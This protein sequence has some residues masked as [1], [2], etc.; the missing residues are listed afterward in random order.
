MV[1]RRRDQLAATLPYTT[2]MPAVVVD[3][4]I[5]NISKI[6]LRTRPVEVACFLTML[7]SSTLYFRRQ[8][9][10]DENIECAASG[11]P[12]PEKSDTEPDRQSLHR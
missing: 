2:V 9:A 1:G 11:N 5:V 10:A 6:H 3:R 7:P 4:P 12:N 8:A